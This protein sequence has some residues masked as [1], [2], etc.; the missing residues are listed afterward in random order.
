MIIENRIGQGSVVPLGAARRRR[1]AVIGAR[2]IGRHH[3]RWWHLEGAELVAFAGTS[4]ASLEQAAEGMRKLFPHQARG[5]TDVARL[6]AVETP[7]WVDVCSANACHFEHVQAALAANCRV[8]CEK[9]LVH[10]AGRP[11]GEL[12]AQ[13]DQ[14]LAASARQGATLALCSQ[15]FVAGRLC[16]ELLAELAGGEPLARFA[17]VLASPTRGRPAD[18]LAVWIDLGPHLLAAMQA[19]LPGARPDFSTL[20]RRFEGYHAECRFQVRTPQGASVACHLHVHR[21]EGEP[22]NLR[23][24]ALNDRWFDIQGQNDDQGIFR[25]KIVSGE[26]AYLYE[27]TMQLL[28]RETAAGVP[29]LSGAAMRDNLAWLLACQP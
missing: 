20:E 14:L 1:V 17:G 5:Y 19:V 28:I 24:L 10:A 29:P 26:R 2:G 18:P 27:D 15:Y 16:R 8:L 3:A 13:A 22:A 21:T 11:A 6:L 9:P 12:L 7:D 25:A 23:Q 4:P